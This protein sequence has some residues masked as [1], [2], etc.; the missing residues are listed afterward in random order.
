MA[1]SLPHAW[2]LP[3]F[4]PSDPS[5]PTRQ[6]LARKR[7]LPDNGIVQLRPGEVHEGSLWWMRVGALD[8]SE[9]QCLAAMGPGWRN[10]SVSLPNERVALRARAS[11]APPPRAPAGLGPSSRA[12]GRPCA[13]GCGLGSCL[14]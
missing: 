6:R 12:E 2:Q 8:A 14:G 10:Q 7:G 1:N 4:P 11:H 5:S 3:L 13:G 9:L